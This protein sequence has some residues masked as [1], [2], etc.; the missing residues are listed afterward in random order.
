MNIFIDY[1]SYDM[2]VLLVFI[3]FVSLTL[4]ALSAPI[5]PKSYLSLGLYMAAAVVGMF[6]L[7]AMRR[8]KLRISPKVDPNAKL[9]TNGIYRFIRHPMYLA[10]LLLGGAM[11]VNQYTP[12]RV[13]IAV[14][15]LLDLMIKMIYEER[16]LQKKF[17]EKYSEYLRQTKRLIPFIF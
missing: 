10:V 4:L 16:L 17:G 9:V 14:T 12:L 1:V 7:Q 2:A 13:G 15:L 6:A 8:S 5:L 3:Q 11:L